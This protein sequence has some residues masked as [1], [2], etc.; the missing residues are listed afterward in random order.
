[1]G[2]GSTTACSLALL[3][4]T[5][6]KSSEPPAVQVSRPDLELVSSGNEP[7]RLLRYHAPPGTMQRFGVSIAMELTAGDMGGPVPT[8]VL[9]IVY[10]VEAVMPTGQ[11]VLRATIEEV[12]ALDMP[13]L[14]VS[15]ASLNGPLS[16]LTGLVIHS[17]LSPNGRVTSSKVDSGG[18]TLAPEMSEQI[19]SLVQSFE[20]TM[21]ALPDEP[22]GAGAVWRNSRPI[23]QK[24]LRLKAVNSVSLLAVKGDAIEYSLDTEIHGDDQTIKEADISIDVKD[25]IGNGGGKGTIDLGKLVINSE[26]AAEFHAQM[27]TVGEQAATKMEMATLMKVR[28]L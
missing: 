5:A 27:L 16:K 28:S 17:V 26:L 4:F 6:C 15:A 10:V 20:S 9:T 24:G 21:M 14:K 19:E 2:S 3:A 7:R 18:K 22:V 11:L 13:D 8:I 25:V 23:E 12:K 1:M